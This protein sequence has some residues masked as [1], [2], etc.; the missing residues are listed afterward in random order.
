MES[1]KEKYLELSY[2]LI[3]LSLI[4]FF[5]NSVC[6]KY[7]SHYPELEKEVISSNDRNSEALFFTWEKMLRK[8]G[9]MNEEQKIKAVNEF[10]NENIVYKDDMVLYQKN[11]HWA[12]LAET[13]KNAQ[14]DCEDYAIAKY[15]TL[16][17]LGVNDNKL[18]LKYVIQDSQN[19]LTSH[20]ILVYKKSNSSTE[21]VLDNINGTI[22][23]LKERIDLSVRYSFNS[24]KI[25]I[26]LS[27]YKLKKI[28]NKLPKWQ[29]VLA[30]T[31]YSG[32]KLS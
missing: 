25:W 19:K 22:S 27:S 2:K 23:P 21:M 24:T 32:I 16:R 29:N 9:Q 28:K 12:S 5:S 17:M 26:G 6:A 8:A 13:L 20:M 7:K 18:K 14:G 3:F 31:N 10:F 11:D 4:S 30:K 15:V 1:I